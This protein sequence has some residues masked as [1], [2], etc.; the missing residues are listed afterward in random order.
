MQ[1]EHWYV[2]NPNTSGRSSIF[3]DYGNPTADEV[4]KPEYIR[5]VIHHRNV[6]LFRIRLFDRK[7][8]IHPGG[9]PSL[10]SERIT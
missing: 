1:I 9:H 5:A 6:N 8:R 7:T 2:A 10:Q 3:V 4:A